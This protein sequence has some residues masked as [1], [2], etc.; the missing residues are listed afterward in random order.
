MTL[1][2]MGRSQTLLSSMSLPDPLP[3]QPFTHPVRGT[4]TLPGSKSITNRAL[5]LAALGKGATTLRGALFSRDTR[6]MIAAL[7]ELGFKVEADEAALTIRIEGHN[8]EIPVR[9][10]RIEVGNA[11]TAARF[12][13]AFVCLRPDGIYHFDGDEAMRRRPIGALLEALE[14]QG[15]KA[16]ARAF[17]FTLRTAGLRG[18]AVELD[19]AES[20]QLLSALLMVA[21]HAR[22]PLTVKLKGETVSKPFIA[23]TEQMVQQFAQPQS[24]YVIEGDATAA[25]YFAAL[26]AVTRGKLEI[27]GLNLAIEALQG[28]ASFFR[29]LATQNVI[30]S[31][32]HTVGTGL[33]RQGITADFND[34]SDTFLTLAAIAPLLDG[35]TR[36]TGIAHTRKQETDRVAGMARELTKLGQRV[37][38]TE[39]SLEIHPQPLRAGQVIATYHDHRFAMSFGILGCHDLHGDGRSWL[40]IQDPACCAKT[41]PHFFELLESLRQK[42]LAA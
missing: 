25:S 16:S 30:V 27:N 10:A 24:D 20:S 36:I 22:T 14:S 17:P 35:P 8:G 26:T 6:I 34:F 38:E 23:M 41:F 9:E 3:L 11:G 4:V 13:T 5:I 31:N 40:S 18:G 32:A 7:R 15:A 42:S 12:L 28:D 21:P 2:A 33:Q 19:A 39:D 37:I 29:L 1:A